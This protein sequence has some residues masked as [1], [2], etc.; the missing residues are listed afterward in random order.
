MS[1][2]KVVIDEIKEIDVEL[3]RLQEHTKKLK[4]HKKKLEG[5][6]QK[7]LEENSTPGFR[8]GNTAVVIEKSKV[9][10]RKVKKDKID[11]INNLL[12]KSGIYNKE[13]AQKIL[14]ETQGVPTES[15]KLKIV[16]Q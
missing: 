13:L 8:Y 7:Y 15:N 14:S 5:V 2:I 1:E 3:K 4:N 16:K 9:R 11:D 10:K 12:E 6:V